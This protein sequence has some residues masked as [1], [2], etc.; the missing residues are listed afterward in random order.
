MT[1]TPQTTQAS[2]PDGRCWCCDGEYRTDEMVSLGAHPEVTIC[3]GCARFLHRRA[4]DLE[5]SDTRTPGALARRAVTS[6]RDRVIAADLHHR[7]VLGRAL[8]WIDR[9]LP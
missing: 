1:T 7:P 8:R 2:G 5:D 6:V 9:R 4:R 3:T